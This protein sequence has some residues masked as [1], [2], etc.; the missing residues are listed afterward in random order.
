[1]TLFL[2]NRALGGATFPALLPPL[3][4]SSILGVEIHTTLADI[5]FTI[6]KLWTERIFIEDNSTTVIGWIQGDPDQMGAYSL[7][8]DI[9]ISL[10]HSAVVS[11]WYIYRKANSAADWMAVF[12]VEH[13]ED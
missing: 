4:E 2:C 6:R 9:W 12:V 3:L 8:R 11:F 1:M 13:S 5:T 10:R 7:I